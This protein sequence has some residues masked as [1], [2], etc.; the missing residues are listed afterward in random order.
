MVSQSFSGQRRCETG[1][2]LAEIPFAQQ[3]LVTGSGKPNV[4]IDRRDRL[5]DAAFLIGEGRH[6]A[7]FHFGFLLP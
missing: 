4:Q 3:D 7:L 2:I 6:L 5:A 1:R